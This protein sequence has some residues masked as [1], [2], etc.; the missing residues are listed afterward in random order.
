M[1]K[2]LFL[3][4]AAIVLFASSAGGAITGITRQAAP[5]AVQ[6][7]QTLGKDD[8]M[9]IVLSTEGASAI[10]TS[11]KRQSGVIVR[12]DDRV[13]FPLDFAHRTY[14]AQKTDVAVAALRNERTLIAKMQ[15]EIPNL[16]GS[17]EPNLAFPTLAPLDA[18]AEIAGVVAHAYAL[19]QQGVKTPVRLWL[20][21]DLPAPPDVLQEQMVGAIFLPITAGHALLRSETQVRGGWV[22]GLDTLSVKEIEV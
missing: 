21:D 10:E 16:K 3:A 9:Q 6:L 4:A 15:I 19:R 11:R 5:A 1:R 7:Q 2:A 8:R 13:M 18:K 17:N 22:T 20:A 14:F 12:Y